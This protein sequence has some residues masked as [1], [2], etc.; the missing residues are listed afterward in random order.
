M[1]IGRRRKGHREDEYK[2]GNFDV[3]RIV[4][5]TIVHIP[6]PTLISLVH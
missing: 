4:F 2:I 6:W 5:T 3:S 1:Y